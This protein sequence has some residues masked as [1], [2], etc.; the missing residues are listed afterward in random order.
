MIEFL[1]FAR[2]SM[3]AIGDASWLLVSIACLEL[4]VRTR[5]T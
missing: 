5:P 1:N 2:E 3:I 4:A